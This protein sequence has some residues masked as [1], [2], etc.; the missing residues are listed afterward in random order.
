MG[1]RTGGGKTAQRGSSPIRI[2]VTHG[3]LG[4]ARYPLLVGHYRGD[5]LAGAE[6]HL[7][8]KLGGRLSRWRDLGLYPGDI[9]T[10]EVIIEGEPSTGAVVVGLGEVGALTV[11]DLQFAL[12]RGLLR[13]A[14]VKSDGP[15][16]EEIKLNISTL[17][18][19]SGLGGLSAADCVG[20]LLRAL[21]RVNDAVSGVRFDNVEIIELYESRA[22]QIWREARIAIDDTAG[23]GKRRTFELDGLVRT[24]EGGR[25]R[26][27]DEEDRTWWQPMTITEE[28][29]DDERW[30]N[31][32]AATG[33]ARAAG[34]LMPAQRAL[35]DQFIKEAIAW[36]GRA[37]GCT[38]GRALFELLLPAELKDVSHADRP[39]RLTLDR[40]SAHY[41]WEL[42]DDRRPWSNDGACATGGETRKPL[43]VRAPMIRQMIRSSVRRSL[44]ASAGTKRALVIGDPWGG[45][46]RPRVPLPGAVAEAYAV[47]GILK[48]NGFEVTTLVK[49]VSAFDVMM[50]LCCQHWTVVHIAAH[51]EVDANAPQRSGVLLGGGVVLNADNLARLLPI[52]PDLVFLNC[53]HLGKVG[54]EPAPPPQAAG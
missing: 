27:T 44:T 4:F 15:N 7:D 38:P 22:H 28:K 13:Y 46:T 8:H 9:G 35:V 17:L 34:A 39:L 6:K 25:R 48:A 12:T 37:G 45:P 18:I 41:P 5:T 1:G 10:A 20:A 42:L 24:G 23:G 33:A 52:A 32:V 50:A 43:A 26:A 30:L 19:G 51:G 54:D 40:A 53:C 16:R 3:N 2:T 47:E 36:R 49:D 29:R 31:F 11:G 21:S 14:A